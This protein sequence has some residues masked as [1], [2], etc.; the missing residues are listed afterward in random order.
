MNVDVD[1]LLPDTDYVISFVGA[2]GNNLYPNEGLFTD[3]AGFT[4]TGERQSVLLHTKSSLDQ[5]QYEDGKGWI[6]CPP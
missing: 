3:Y 1:N 2:S 6:F 4:A 5:G